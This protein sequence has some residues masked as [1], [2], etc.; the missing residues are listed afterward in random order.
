LAIV[1]HDLRNPLNT[2]KMNST[3]LQRRIADADARRNLGSIERAVARMETL[4]RDLVDATRIEHG[5]LEVTMQDEPVG[6]IVEEAMELFSPLARAR[7]IAIETSTTGGDAIVSCDRGRLLQVLGN[8]LGNALKFTPEGGRV[9]VRTHDGEDV[10]RFEVEDSGPGI[11]PEHLPHIFERYWNSDRRGTGL[12]LFIAQSIVRAHGGQIRV[13]SEP[14]LGATF[15]FTVPRRSWGSVS[16]D[17]PSDQ[18]VHTE[19]RRS[20]RNAFLVISTKLSR[21]ARE[22]KIS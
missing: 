4:I 3:L 22:E 16:S 11:K 1:A 10:V 21:R 6:A 15:S 8:L 20:V 7:G 12:G 9:V 17:K 13:R 19:V 2:V 18:I 14:G 5:E